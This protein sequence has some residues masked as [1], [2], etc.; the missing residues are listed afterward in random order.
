MKEAFAG[1]VSGVREH[2][3]MQIPLFLFL[4]SGYLNIVRVCIQQFSQNKIRLLAWLILTVGI[5][6]F[7]T[8]FFISVMTRQTAQSVFGEG[9]IIKPP[10]T[11][12]GYRIMHIDPGL[13]DRFTDADA[14]K[15]V[16]S[17]EP[18]F[19]AIDQLSRS[20]KIGAF[21]PEK[22]NDTY[23]HI[24]NFGIAPGIRLLQGNEIR[25]EGYLIVNILHPG[26]S[27][28]FEIPQ[29]PYRFLISLEPVKIVQ[30]EG[31]T[32]AHYN[33]KEPLFNVRVF[34]GEDVILES[35]SKA[36]IPF[37][38]FN[39][40]FIKPTFWILLEI[41]RDPGIPILHI[42]IILITFGTPFYLSVFII[43]LF[44]KREQY[45]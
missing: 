26:T 40:Q 32:V 33:L 20:Y 37:N 11:K 5:M 36:R 12:E 43:G 34:K 6:F 14:D 3:V 42:G 19:T 23:Y 38:G 2:L 29:H 41:V 39:L 7:F 45:V 44:W 30:K 17:Y 9:D 25:D 1:F 24:L 31:M 27:D 8:G 15:G 21:P 28:F 22:I 13:K 16:F 4:L 10:W 18:M 35:N